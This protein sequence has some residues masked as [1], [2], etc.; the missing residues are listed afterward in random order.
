MPSSTIPGKRREGRRER[1]HSFE[2]RR[3]TEG[4]LGPEVRVCDRGSKGGRE[5][6]REPKDADT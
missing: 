5:R 4:I 2:G 3:V 6:E 1:V